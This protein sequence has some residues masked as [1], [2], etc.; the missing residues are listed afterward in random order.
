RSLNTTPIYQVVFALQ[1]AP[2]VVER[3]RGLELEPVMGDELR[4]RFDMTVHV[5]E[6]EAEIGLYW[7]YNR[8]LFDRWRMEQMGRHYLRV[9]EAMIGDVEQEIGSVDLLEVEERRQILEEWNQTLR[10][11]PE[12]TLVDLFEEQVKRTPEAVALVCGD[13]KLNYTEL[14]ERSNQ[15]ADLL[16][17]VGVGAEVRVAICLQE[18]I[19]T[20]IGI[21]GVLKA[22]G[23]YLPL[24][25]HNTSARLKWIMDDSNAPVVLTDEATRSRLPKHVARVISL[26]GDWSEI[27]L[28][29]R[30]NPG[31]RV[32]TQNTAYVIYTSGS[33]GQPKGVEIE[34]RQLTNYLGA[35]KEKMR[36]APGW[37]LALVSSIATDLGHTVLFPAL[38]EGGELHVISRELVM[39]GEELGNYFERVGIEVVKIT[40]THLK[41]IME[42]GRER[43]IPGRL[44][45]LGGEPSYWEWIEELRKKRPGI[46][47]MNHYGPT[48]STVGVLT[49]ELTGEEEKEEPLIGSVPLG[50]PLRNVQAYVLDWNL[51][52]VPV[53]VAG[54]LYIAGAGLAR[55]YLKRPAL[56][57]ERF[58][59]NPYGQPGARMYRSGDLARWRPDGNL[60]FL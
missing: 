52:P 46:R 55:G 39:N 47:I 45:V 56:S 4:V 48:E 54:E 2:R 38:S 8:D 9:L 59:A 13:E 58:V 51:Q 3:M 1:N 41:A 22:G 11:I 50:K 12:A 18:S 30:N 28:R 25:P 10:Q 57:A 31:K 5:Q 21:L 60:E 35:I 34:H 7:V 19:R 33:T 40:P 15:L 44:L 27:G 26:D 6:S 20:M 24:D 32:Q 53:G 23:A 14:N 37:K 29:S 42:G 36:L 16:I 49:K 17:G 43:A